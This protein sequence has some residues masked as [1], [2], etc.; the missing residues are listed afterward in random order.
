MRIVLDMQ[1]AQTESR[2]RGIGRYTLSLA[3]AIVRNRG[4]NEIFLVLSGLFPNTIEPIRAIFRESLPQDHILVWQAP[5]PVRGC[6]TDNNWRRKVAEHIRE[7]FLARLR[8]DIIHIFSL[9]EGYVDDAVT[10]ID[11]LC[12]CAPVSVSCFDLIPLI[13]PEQY[14]EKD[15]LYKQYYLEKIECMRSAS[16]WLGISASSCKEIVDKLQL[17]PESVINI[18]SAADSQFRQQTYSINHCAAVLEKF[19]L[20]R[21]IVLY[22]GDADS[23]KNLHNL[24][25]AYS[26]IPID[27]R[28]THQLVF[29]GKISTADS[30][31][32]Q[33]E[34]QRVGLGTDEL[35]IIGYVSN[36]ELVL[37]YNTCKLFVFPSWHEGFGLPLL[38]AMSCGAAV[39]AAN[40]SSIPEVIGLEAALFDAHSVTAIAQMITKALTDSSFRKTLQENAKVQTSKFSW[41]ESALRAIKAFENIHKKCSCADKQQ[42]WRPRLAFVSPLP[43]ER[44]GIADYSSML[45]PELAKFYDIDVVVSQLSVTDP[46]ILANCS[47]RNPEWLR[48]NRS[49]YDRVIYQFGNSPFHQYMFALLEHVPGVVILNDFFLS[50]L[51]AY[52]EEANVVPNAWAQALY[53]SHGY[54]AVSERYHSPSA[55]EVKNK[56]PANFEVLANALGVIAHSKHSVRLAASWYGQDFATDWR[57]IPLARLLV[58]DIDRAEARSGIG[59]EDHDFVVCS[60]GFLDATKLNHRLLDAWLHSSLA[61]EKDCILI[62]VG[63]NND[64]AYG[65][66]L[67]EMVGN[68]RVRFTGWTSIS[69][70]HGYLAAADVA[71]QLRSLSRGE[72]SA[73]VL[74]CMNYALPTIVNAHGAMADLDENAVWMLPDEFTDAQLIDALETQWRNSPKRIALGERARKAIESNHSPYACAIMFQEAIEKFYADAKGDPFFLLQSIA[75]FTKHELKDSDCILLAQAISQSL[76]KK[77]SSK[78]L[79]LDVSATCRV[80][81]KTGIER[82]TRALTKALLEIPIDGYRV[83]PVYLSN[84]G[85]VWHYNFASKFTLKLIDCPQDTLSDTVVEPRSGDVLL[86]MDLSGNMV[87]EAD[88]SNLFSFFKNFNASIY[89]IIYDILPIQFNEF[90]PQGADKQHESWLHIATKYDG[91]ACISRTVASEVKQWLNDTHAQN[92]HGFRIGTFAL[93]ADVS[94]SVPTLGLP[95]NANAILDKIKSR[96]SFLMVGTIEPRKGHLLVIDAFEQTLKEGLD[97]NLIIVGNEGWK[98]LPAEMRRTIPGIVERI[99]LHPEFSKRLLWIENAS[100]EYLEKIYTASTCL[101]AASEGEGF[102]LPIIEAAHHNLPVIARDIPVFKEVAGASATYFCGGEAASL[103]STMRTWVRSYGNYG[104]ITSEKIMQI[105]W[106]ESAKQLVRFLLAKP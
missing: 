32:L 13:Y 6:D 8:P 25:R 79:L 9:F 34:A 36:D 19:R 96:I 72:T 90:F 83:E 33:N 29:A 3:E 38:E 73:A 91:V 42:S 69:D 54:F 70:Y 64:S 101:I 62:F 49:L 14:L 27:L 106:T 84:E 98:D 68:A 87:L 58:T 39:I 17:A 71:V 76:A 88:A 22:A 57:V 81:L 52:L 92:S 80:D 89:F 43:P 28:K 16:L 11:G 99:R 5:G 77:E 51:L 46:W 1:G 41:D 2:Y 74:D 45:L 82:A 97:A 21:S 23:R 31:S 103:A 56:F 30:D 59:V 18:S 12:T 85:G 65:S 24:V 67:R 94:R 7:A 53:Y 55:N 48:A 50:S 104:K 63:G 44:T 40:A 15:S 10:S 35:R 86:V 78:R 47:I 102:G 100:D 61:H 20:N 60:F 26:Q 75:Q 105:S 4:E 37:L 95:N 66:R 93:G